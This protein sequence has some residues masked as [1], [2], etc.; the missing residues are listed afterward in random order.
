M[1]VERYIL[2]KYDL[3]EDGIEYH[4]L[5]RIININGKLIGQSY[6]NGAWE[7]YEGA[8]SFFLAPDEAEYITEAQAEEIKKIIDKEEDSDDTSDVD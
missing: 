8:L 4:D 6:E 2:R 1:K 3:E 5:S 7:E